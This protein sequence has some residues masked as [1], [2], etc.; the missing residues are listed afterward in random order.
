MLKNLLLLSLSVALQSNLWAGEICNNGGNLVVF[1]NYEGGVL[2]ISVDVDIANLAIGIVTYEAVTVNFSGAFVGSINQVIFSGFNAPQINGLSGIVPIIYSATT[3]NIGIASYLGNNQA[4]IN[5]PLVNCI[6]AGSGCTNS[7]ED[8]GGG[9]SSNQIVQFFLSELNNGSLLH[10]HTT[11]YEAFTGA[12]TIALSQGGNCCVSEPTTTPNP[13]YTGGDTYDFIPD[14]ANL[15]D[16][17]VTLDLSFYP[18]LFQPDL[19][20]GYVWS[21]GQTGPIVTFSEPGTY[22]FYVGDYCHYDEATYLR[23]TIVIVECCITPLPPLVVE[24][25]SVC[26]NAVAGSLEALPNIGGSITWYANAALTQVLAQSNFYT[27]STTQSGTFTVYVTENS[28]GCISESNEA[29]YTV[30]PL[31]VVATV[32]SGT[33]ELLEGDSLSISSLST[34]GN[35][36]STGDVGPEITVDTS[37]V[38]SLV[39][40]DINGCV[41]STRVIVELIMPDSSVLVEEP[42][43]F[44]PNAFTPN[45]DGVNDVFRVSGSGIETFEMAIFNRWGETVFEA[46]D[47]D[48][49][50]VGG[51]NDYFVNDGI[52]H[53][54]AIYSGHSLQQKTV[55]G[56]ILMLR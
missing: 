9:N 45:N 31:P 41:D 28:D 34:T 49:V 56:H 4:F 2:N 14:E 1:S 13:I 36:W 47:I 42:M 15:C 6:T 43:L 54:R 25:V 38:Y 27:P 11:Q 46:N 32:P 17:P 20:P 5:I 3:N 33:V 8:T 18:V 22:S 7:T 30:W 35:L 23:D 52:Y 50:W 53:Y 29:Q 26:Q 16:G 40:T 44:I 55:T 10:S 51:K 48:A 24:N 37:G 21:D 39:V 19:Y 12:E